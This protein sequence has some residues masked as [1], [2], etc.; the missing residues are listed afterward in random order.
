MLYSHL[1]INV[2][3]YPTMARVIT[4]VLVLNV[5][6]FIAGLAS[7]MLKLDFFSFLVV[8]IIANFVGFIFCAVYNRV[9]TRQYLIAI[10]F[11]YWLS[12]LPFLFL[13]ADKDVTLQFLVTMWFFSAITVTLYVGISY[14]VVRLFIPPSQR[15]ASSTSS[16]NLPYL[17]LNEMIITFFLGNISN[18]VSGLIV[19]SLKTGT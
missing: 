17:R 6:Q 18:V 10:G 2:W 19:E 13:I 7:A 3:G 11:F 1:Y 15:G 4:G 14:V 12:Q 8:V 16:T 9:Q 5:L